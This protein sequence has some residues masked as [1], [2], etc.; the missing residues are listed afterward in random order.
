MSE[1]KR[2]E[3]HHAT[4]LR[5][6]LVAA[7]EAGKI[8]EMTNT[9]AWHAYRGTGTEI[10]RTW[11][12]LVYHPSRKRDGKKVSVVCTDFNVLRVIWSQDYE[13]LKPSE[14]EPVYIDDAGWGFPLMG[15]MIGANRGQA[16]RTR[17]VDVKHFQGANMDRKSYLSE[18]SRLGFELLRTL[19]AT[20][21]TCRVEICTGFINTQLRDQ[22]RFAGWEVS[23]AEIT[24]RLQDSLE[25][26]FKQQVID[27]LGEDVYY[28]PKELS[29][30]PAI[31]AAYRR[32]L[33]YGR[34]FYPQLLKTGWK[35]LQTANC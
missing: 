29:G 34:E 21:D 11:N 14:R 18:Y 24:G 25:T 20:P 30:P 19:K 27:Q 17:M 9:Q 4:E 10:P 28:D 6:R 13:K 5:A 35:S 26:I 15:V 16:V 1:S 2:L 7:M 8:V 3:L 33:D 12:V 22:L 23:V 31:A 32:A